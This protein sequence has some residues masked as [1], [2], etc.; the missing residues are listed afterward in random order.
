MVDECD[1]AQRGR[2][3]CERAKAISGAREATRVVTVVVRETLVVSASEGR[4]EPPWVVSVV[5]MIHVI[6]SNAVKACVS[7][8]RLSAAHGKHRGW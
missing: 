4:A 5:G 2:S 1:P 7:E 8:R 6:R 3:V